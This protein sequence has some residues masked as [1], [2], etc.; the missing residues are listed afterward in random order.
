MTACIVP[1]LVCASVALAAF[2]L[3]RW[4]MRPRP[5]RDPVYES[6][7]ESQRQHWHILQAA[8]AN[9]ADIRDEK[10]TFGT[11]ICKIENEMDALRE[12]GLEVYDAAKKLTHEVKPADRAVKVRGR[13]RTHP[14]ERKRSRFRHVGKMVR[15]LRSLQTA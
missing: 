2:L 4:S 3:G 5:K 11:I 14:F 12:H 6:W 1:F 15:N 13:R 9:W 8:L 10:H 7:S